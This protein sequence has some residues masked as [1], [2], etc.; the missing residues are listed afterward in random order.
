MLSHGVEKSWL[1]QILYDILDYQNKTLLETM[2]QERFL[3]V[4]EHKGW[5]IYEDLA[6]KILQWEST[7]E[8]SRITN[9]LFEK[10]PPFN[11]DVHSI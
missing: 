9:L 1:C 4:D 8:E 7:P 11:R 6:E 10:K 5:K 2:N 3:K